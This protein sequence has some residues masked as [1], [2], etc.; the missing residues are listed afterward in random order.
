M[1]T[2]WI[3]ISQK[4]INQPSKHEIFN[5]SKTHFMLS[6][7]DVPIAYRSN[8]EN[9]DDK[10]FVFHIEF[11]YLSQS[12][13]I[14]NLRLSDDLEVSIG[15]KSKRLYAISMQLNKDALPDTI[16]LDS[17]IESRIDRVKRDSDQFSGGN[18]DAIRRVL[19]TN[20]I[21]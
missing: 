17:Y 3:S 10:T 13:T 14:K 15:T 9:I 6:P 16:D 18:R 12:E 1:S 7:S 4:D 5:G 2:G 20:D 21:S 8:R 19:M 11:R